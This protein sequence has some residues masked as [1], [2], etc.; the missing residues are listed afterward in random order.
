VDY[1]IACSVG[2]GAIEPR[3]GESEVSTAAEITCRD[4][5]PAVPPRW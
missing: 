3:P 1:S 5:A 4:P 2:V